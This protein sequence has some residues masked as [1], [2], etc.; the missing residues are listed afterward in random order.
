MQNRNTHRQQS[1]IS[2][3]VPENTRL[4]LI[5][6]TESE[7]NATKIIQGSSEYPLSATGRQQAIQA[8]KNISQLQPV[9]VISSPLSRA[10]DTAMLA[11]GRV[12]YQDNRLRERE[13]GAWEGRPRQELETAYAGALENDNLRPEE[14]ETTESV[15]TRI[16]E[17][18]KEILAAS[19]AGLI[20]GISHGA[21]LR[22]L[23]RHLGGTGNRF[24]YLEGLALD[25]DLHI[26]KRVTIHETKD[27]A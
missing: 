20:L 14:Y 17:A 8:A 1:A 6:Y 21:V 3:S 9:T 5:R 4:L 26:L 11:A 24:G 18:L 16:L 13:A 27:M 19:P 7:G 22:V 25:D 2:A 10:I 23:D 12:D 15:I